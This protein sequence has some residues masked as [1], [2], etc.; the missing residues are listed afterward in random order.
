[1]VQETT[2]KT[3]LDRMMDL[4]VPAEKPDVWAKEMG[5]IV[6]EHEAP[7]KVPPHYAVSYVYENHKFYELCDMWEK[8][9]V[10][11]RIYPIMKKQYWIVEVE[12]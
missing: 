1:L 12:R 10:W 9:K 11:F 4:K 8:K 7:E 6:Y 5:L 2:V 3:P